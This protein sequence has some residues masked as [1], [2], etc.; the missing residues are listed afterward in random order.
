MSIFS[1]IIFSKLKYR[2]P[3]YSALLICLNVHAQEP[4][5]YWPFQLSYADL[6]S[7]KHHGVID[8]HDSNEER[9][10][11]STNDM[12]FTIDV[13]DTLVITILS[14]L[15]VK[16][17]IPDPMLKFKVYSDSLHYEIHMEVS[18]LDDT[19]KALMDEVITEKNAES[20]GWVTMMH[21]LKTGNMASF[22]KYKACWKAGPP[23]SYL[24]WLNGLLT[25]WRV[26]VLGSV[27]G[28]N[29][30][31]Y[32]FQEIPLSKYGFKK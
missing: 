19:G 22:E 29:I 12:N 31:I 11:F 16:E 7:G 3:C 18:P 28:R 10:S 14:P 24:V 6:V 8:L 32:P 4:A 9:I 23:D 15:E 21:Y 30:D 1:S 2:F 5:M 27:K 26:F 13:K 17:M 20:V 25:V